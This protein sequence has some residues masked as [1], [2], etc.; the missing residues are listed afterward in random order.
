MRGRWLRLTVVLLLLGGLAACGDDGGSDGDAEAVDSLE[1]DVAQAIENP[2]GS[3]IS[4]GAEGMSVEGE[5]EAV[6][7]D[8]P[9]DV[10]LEEGETFSCAADVEVGGVPY[11]ADVD[12]EVG[13]DEELLVCSLVSPEGGFGFIG[14]TCVVSGDETPPS[15]SP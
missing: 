2:P 9:D 13:A 1:D 11:Q 3:V 6:A 10:V 8:C 7:V 12:L 14:T 15:T 4:M 5:L